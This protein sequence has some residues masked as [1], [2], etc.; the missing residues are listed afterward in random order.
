MATSAFH[1]A[2]CSVKIVGEHA[3]VVT[4]AHDHLVGTHKLT[5]ADNPE[6]KAAAAIDQNPTKDSIWPD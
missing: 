2:T 4:A 6:Q 3:D 1:C 5:A